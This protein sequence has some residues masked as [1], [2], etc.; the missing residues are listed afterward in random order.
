[1]VLVK[2]FGVKSTQRNADPLKQ[3]LLQIYV[4]LLELR[5][6][7]QVQGSTSGLVLRICLDP[8]SSLWDAKVCYFGGLATYSFPWFAK[9]PKLLQGVLRGGVFKL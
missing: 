5:K 2:D 8:S 6:V 4:C 3:K 7:S 1:M 9:Y